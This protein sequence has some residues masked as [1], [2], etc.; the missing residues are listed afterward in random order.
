MDELIELLDANGQPTGQSCLKSIAHQQGLFHASVHIW[1]YTTNGQV[2]LQKRKHT[3]NIFPGLWDVSVAGHISFG[4]KELISAIRETEEEIGLTVNEKDLK[5]LGTS[6]HKNEHANKLIDFELHHLYISLLKAP[7][8]NLKIQE[9]EVAA[10]KLL[11]IEEFKAE[12][13]NNSTNYVPHGAD[14][15]SRIVNAI[16]KALTTN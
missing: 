14:Y 6:R 1:F 16:Q 11:S 10:I 2:L 5:Y 15:Y 7:F 4:E 13:R 8:S 12:L 9:T 3:K